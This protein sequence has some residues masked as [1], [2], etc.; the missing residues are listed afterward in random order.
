MGFFDCRRCKSRDFIWY[1]KF[2]NSNIDIYVFLEFKFTGVLRS[3][4]V[5]LEFCPKYRKIVMKVLCKEKK[6]CLELIDMVDCIWSEKNACAFHTKLMEIR[7]KL[8]TSSTVSDFRSLSVCYKQNFADRF[9]CILLKFQI[10][11]GFKQNINHYSNFILYLNKNKKI[12]FGQ[13]LCSSTF[14]S[15]GAKEQ[16][17]ILIRMLHRKSVVNFMSLHQHIP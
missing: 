9:H 11:V 2:R 5:Q 17:Q 14:P 4:Q 13:S 15:N 6:V 16:H 12:T 1:L 8:K 3:F 7:W 10:S